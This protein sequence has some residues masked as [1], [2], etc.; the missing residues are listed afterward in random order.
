MTHKF[1]YHVPLPLPLPHVITTWTL[2]LYSCCLGLQAKTSTHY[3]SF[4]GFF[5][6]VFVFFRFFFGC[7]LYVIT[8]KMFTKYC[9]K[10]K[11]IKSNYK[12]QQYKL[13]PIYYRLALYNIIY[14][15]TYNYSAL[16]TVISAFIRKY[17]LNDL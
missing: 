2:L 3:V 7:A 12:L 11:K 9:I 8:G 5:L 1:P 4:I 10:V 16:S 13:K 14:I 6:D 17:F 15:F